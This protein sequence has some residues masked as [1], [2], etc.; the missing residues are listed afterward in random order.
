MCDAADRVVARIT[1]QRS[2]VR[3]GGN[4]LYDY[5]LGFDVTPNESMRH[6]TVVAALAEYFYLRVEHGGPLRALL[7]WT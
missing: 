5:T 7:W 1:R 4:D 6:L 2:P 3:S